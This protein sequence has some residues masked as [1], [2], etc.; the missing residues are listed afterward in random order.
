MVQRSFPIVFSLLLSLISVIANAQNCLQVDLQAVS[1]SPVD[2]TLQ[3]GKE[4][5]LEVVMRNNGPCE[6]PKGEATAQIT[7]N[8]EHVEV[9]SDIRFSDECGHWTFLTS[10]SSGNQK[11]LFF[12]NNGSALP[13]GGKF[14]AF[15]F[16]VKAKTKSAGISTI[17]LASS[18]SASA[19][20][21][22]MNGN[23]QSA[24]TEINIAGPAIPKPPVAEILKLEGKPDDCYAV[25]KWKT[26]LA[27][28]SFEIETAFDKV[29]FEKT[30]SVP[31]S[32]SGDHDYKFESYQANSRKY[33]R[34]KI[35]Q[36]NGSFTYS[37]IAEVQTTCKV[38][39]GF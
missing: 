19:K 26:P 7:L 1:I 39:K 9:P 18:L 5:Q 17:T 15:R 11:N 38:K 22:D 34:L 25:L 13:V 21:S 29:N 12:R 4:T 32:T 33:Y 10:T 6:I 2:V 37:T 27:V 28:D 3:P 14:C 24:Y 30:G 20:S 8:T 36:K 31:G 23:N 16:S 35:I